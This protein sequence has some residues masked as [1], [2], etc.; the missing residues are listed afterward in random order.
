MTTAGRMSI[1]FEPDGLVSMVGQP[2]RFWAL[3]F[4]HPIAGATLIDC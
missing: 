2:E 1:D 3:D 4:D